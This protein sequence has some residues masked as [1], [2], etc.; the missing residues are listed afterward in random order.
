MT[1]LNQTVADLLEE[2]GYTSLYDYIVKNNKAFSD[3][4]IDPSKTEGGF[5]PLTKALTFKTEA[6]I[7][8]SFAEEFVHLYQDTYYPA[9]I[10]QYIGYGYPNIEFE[11]KLTL[12]IL[13]VVGNRG[14]PKF[15]AAQSNGDAYLRWLYDLTYGYTKIPTYSDLIAKPTDSGSKNYWDFLSDFQKDP[16]KNPNNLQ[17]NPSLLPNALVNI[18]TLKPK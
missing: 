2:Y 1:I 6:S 16:S 8:Y 9:G 10:Y 7:S 17:I 11:A 14:C 4:K 13:C 3:V 18:S 5:D 15:G 12:D